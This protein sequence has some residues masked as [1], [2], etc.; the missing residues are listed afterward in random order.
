[1][2]SEGETPGV[3]SQGYRPMGRTTRL[4]IVWAAVCTAA[5]AGVSAQVADEPWLMYRGM[6][7]DDLR[8]ALGRVEL[9]LETL[10]VEA[11]RTRKLAEAGA[12]AAMELA[13]TKAS[14]AIALAERDELVGLVRWMSYLQTLEDKNRTFSEEEHFQLF[15]GHLEPRVRLAET[16]TNL[17][18]A[19]HA[20]NDR[21]IQRRAVSNEEFER[22]GDAFADALARQKL[23]ET[24][25][26][27]ARLAL[28]VRQGKR[29]YVEVESITKAESIRQ[30]RANI[31]ITALKGV[32][33]RLARLQALKARGVAS[34]AEIDAVEETKKVYEQARDE[35]KSAAPEPIP[36]PGKIKRPQIR[37]VQ[38][39]GSEHSPESSFE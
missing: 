10:R 13:E 6:A 14:L 38:G 12:V 9:K 11:A 20:V 33:H 21:L 22:S 24:Q 18:A 25:A 4:A 2:R 37:L 36:P 34:Q 32:E 3:W 31:W 17:M 16:V 19:R 8:M 35:A 15:L 1:M 39:R 30:A 27:A 5:L 28:E 7:L 23:Y 29:A 26:A